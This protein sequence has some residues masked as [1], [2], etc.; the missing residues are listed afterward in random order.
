MPWPL[1][2]HRK[3]LVLQTVSTPGRGRFVFTNAL[4]MFC[5]A[6]VALS[7]R[8]PL[9]LYRQLSGNFLLASTIESLSEVA[10]LC[11]K[12]GLDKVRGG[13]WCAPSLLPAPTRQWPP[14]WWCE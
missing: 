6:F 4:Y 13:R 12:T 8:P 5:F 3:S 1:M 10:A 7:T 2:P 11:D 14:S 9:S